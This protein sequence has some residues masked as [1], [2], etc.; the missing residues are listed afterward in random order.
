MSVRR[1]HKNCLDNLTPKNPF[2]YLIVLTGEV[3][4]GLPKLSLL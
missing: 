1:G 4:L 2:L 3:C